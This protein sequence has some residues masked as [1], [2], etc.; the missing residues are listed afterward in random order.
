MKVSLI[1]LTYNWPAA[2]ARVLAGVAAQR[3]L[4]DEV[5]V[6]DDGSGPDTAAVVE[7]ARTRFPVPLRHVWQE[8]FGFRAARARNRGIAAS[9]GD[10]VILIDGDMLLHPS[11]VADH[12]MLAERGFFL[13]GGR[14]KATEAETAQL[15]AGGAPVFAPW[16]HADFAA[17]DATRRLYAFRQPWLARWKSRAQSGGRVMSC[18]MSF[19]R[20]DLLRVNGFDERMEGYGA[21]DRELAARFKNAGVRRRALKWAALAVHLEHA[22]RAQEEV[23]DPG[24]PNNRLLQATVEQKLVRCEQ[25]IDSH[26]AEFAVRKDADG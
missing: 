10:Y 22:T 12:L 15:L 16:S 20:E 21:E 3:R 5:I 24:L 13:Q 23:D 14:I 6:A 1:V 11:F 8:D 26:L 7:A 9:R 19:W 4:P 17:F 25:G 2:L 18:N